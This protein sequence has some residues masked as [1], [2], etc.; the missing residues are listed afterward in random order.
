MGLL[1]EF[2]EAGQSGKEVNTTFGV[3]VPEGKVQIY[4]STLLQ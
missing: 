4:K 3:L 1:R 2:F